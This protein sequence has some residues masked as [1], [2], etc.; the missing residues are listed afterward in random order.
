ME[1]MIQ[2]F[3]LV[4]LAVMVPVLYSAYR[5][6]VTPAKKWLVIVIVGSIFGLVT[7]AKLDTKVEV[8]QARTNATIEQTKVLP[9]KIED[10]SWDKTKADTV[11]ITEQDLK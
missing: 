6:V 8:T 3:W 10:N 7:P 4:K 1:I 11:G 5:L 9:P 2:W